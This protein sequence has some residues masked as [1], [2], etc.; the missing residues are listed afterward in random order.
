MPVLHLD[1]E[2]E[3]IMAIR[4]RLSVALD[5]EVQKQLR[6]LMMDLEMTCKMKITRLAVQILAPLL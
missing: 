6:Q 4:H 2:V 1:L 3:T 5:L